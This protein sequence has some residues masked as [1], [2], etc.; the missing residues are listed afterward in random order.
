MERYVW[1]QRLKPAGDGV[2]I[3]KNRISM[4]NIPLLFRFVGYP[5]RDACS[6]RRTVKF[7]LG[8]AIF[9]LVHVLATGNVDAQLQNGLVGFWSF[10]EGTGTVAN[11]SSGNGNAG[12]LINGPTW[13]SGKSGTALSFDGTNDYLQIPHE[14]SLNLSTALTVSAW[15]NNATPMDPGL[16]QDHY[17]IIASKG[18]PVDGGS[19]SLAW[20]ANDGSLFFFVGRGDTGY[21]YARFSYDNSEVGTWHLITAVLANGKISL[22]QDGVLKAGPIGIDNATIRTESNPLRVGSLGTSSNSLRN[23]DGLIDEL[24]IYNRALNADEIASLYQQDNQSFNFSLTNSMSLSAAQGSSATNTIKANLVTGSP[25]TVSFSASGLPSGA[26]A[27]FSQKTC[28]PTCSSL[29]TIATTASTPTGTYTI[30]VT[31]SGG[32]VTKTTSFNLTVTSAASVIT[33]PVEGTTFTPGQSVTATGSGTNLSWNIDLIKDGLPSFKT[34]S[35]SSITFTVPASATSSQIIRITLTGDNGS[36]TREYN[37]VTGDSPSAPVG[38]PTITPTVATPTITP[39]G[40]SFT[41]SVSVM[42]QTAT[43]DASIFY[44]TN[45]STPTQSSTLYTG[46]FTLTSTTT[47]KAI[48]FKSGSNPSAQASANFTIVASAAQLTLA[49]QDNADNENDFTIERKTGTDGAYSQIG[50]VGANVTSYVDN[51]VSRGV[52]YCYRVRAVNSAGASAY[53]NEACKT[54]P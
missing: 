8:S 11:D 28:S 9:S 25:E 20:R 27:S 45:G 39:S 37:I 50:S 48:A 7:L 38:S 40:G 54:V 42:L 6:Q 4:L 13:A 36:A 18:W 53:S 1:R 52:N 19:W 29:L 12:T 16:D 15:I 35:G 10:N 2:G 5:Q 49:W 22:Y 34:G 43:S 3:T 21:R 17:R 26:S 51:S 14:E 46:A 32:E 44:T 30:T 31:G 41:G 47:L 33:S 23:W 24:R